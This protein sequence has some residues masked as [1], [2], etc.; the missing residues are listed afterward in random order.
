MPLEMDDLLFQ[1]GKHHLPVG[2]RNALA[3]MRVLQRSSPLES[4]LAAR[5]P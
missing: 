2:K 4:A 3:C 1:K 5:W